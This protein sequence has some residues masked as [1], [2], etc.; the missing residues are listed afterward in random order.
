MYSSKPSVRD[1]TCWNVSQK[2]KKKK[3]PSLS[4]SRSD[5]HSLHLLESLLLELGNSPMQNTMHLHKQT[6]YQSQ[7]LHLPTST[8]FGGVKSIDWPTLYRCET[9][10]ALK[11]DKKKK[12]KWFDC[13]QGQTRNE[14]FILL[15]SITRLKPLKNLHTMNYWQ[16]SLFNR[17]SVLSWL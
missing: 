3:S 13:H 5:A 7:F 2:K 12:K 8:R 9:R 15:S 6:S 17:Y 16:V 11:R 14:C 1:R 4:Y 10:P